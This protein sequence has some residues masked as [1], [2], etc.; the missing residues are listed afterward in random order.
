MKKPLISIVTP[1]YNQG[2]YIEKTIQSVLNQKYP[3]IEYIIVDGGSTDNTLKIIKQYENQIDY[4]ISENDKGQSD[5]INKGF[6]IA[7][8]EYV[9]WLNSDDIYNDYTVEMLVKNISDEHDLYYGIVGI[10]NQYDEFIDIEK[11]IP[12]LNFLNLLY[13]PGTT[14]QPGSFYSKKILEKVGFLNERLNFVMDWDLFLRIL[15]ESKAKFIPHVMA[16]IRYHEQSKSMN[17]S[18]N[19]VRE[20]YD[21]YKK[22]K[23]K[24]LS[25]KAMRYYK[26]FIFH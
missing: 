10:I 8:G 24:P 15:L 7:K 11:F 23:G 16:Y 17:K 19:D 13:G 4:W 1:S 26:Y 3:F 21:T 12:N 5:A 14:L 20:S 22:Y 2:S 6:K 18:P 25:L 9:G